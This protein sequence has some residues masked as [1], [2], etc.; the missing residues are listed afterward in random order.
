MDFA[1]LTCWH[2]SLTPETGR[3]FVTSV[4]DRVDEL[5]PEYARSSR[6]DTDAYHIKGTAEAMYKVERTSLYGV[7]EETRKSWE[8]KD[9]T[10]KSEAATRRLSQ[11]YQFNMEL[12]QPMNVGVWNEIFA[13]LYFGN[14]SHGIVVP[15]PQ[16]FLSFTPATDWS[17]SSLTQIRAI[18]G[19]DG[20]V[21]QNSNWL[22]AELEKTVTPRNLTDLKAQQQSALADLEEEMRQVNE[23]ETGE[24]AEI[25]AQITQ[26]KASME[27]KQRALM[28]DLEKKKDEMEDKMNQLNAQIFM[29]DAQIYA[30]QCFA[31]E[32]VKFS[33]IRKGANAP[34]TEPVIIYQELRFLDEDLG[35]MVSMYQLDWSKISLFEDFLRHSPEALETFAPDKRCITLVRLSKTNT[36][37]GMSSKHPYSNLLESYE[38]FHGSTVGIIIRNGENLYLGWTDDDRVH[39][40][41]DF[42][43]SKTVTDIKPMEQRPAYSDELLERRAQRQEKQ[44]A[45]NERMEVLNGVVS[46]AFVFNVL[47]GIVKNTN[48]LPLPPGE[49]LTKP[50]LYVRYSLSDRCLED[51]RFSDFDD[52]IE[53]A[54]RDVAEGDMVLTMQFLRPH[55]DRYDHNDRGIG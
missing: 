13:Y 14:P 26:L 11:F 39:I 53:L 16:E 33:H 52:L 7:S 2:A 1:A 5:Y 12:G 46:R 28:L 22:P 49:S 40:Q 10:A 24:L 54:N 4:K 17:D 23:G 48:W 19:V 36:T 38:Y 55:S 20:D 30:I 25:K 43:I 42:I 44:K 27:A 51:H 45:Y 3:L 32:T 41:D 21:A 50:S 15:T 35:R 47:Q 31:G 6:R 18:L 34:T 37:I 9:W 29:L 8:E